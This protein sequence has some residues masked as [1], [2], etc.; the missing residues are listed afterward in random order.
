MYVG[1]NIPKIEFTDYKSENKMKKK[2]TFKIEFWLFES[3]EAKMKLNSI[4]PVPIIVTTVLS[5]FI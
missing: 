2:N 1:R 3:T 4:T 5:A